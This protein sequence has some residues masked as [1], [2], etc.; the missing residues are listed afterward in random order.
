MR[1]QPLGGIVPCFGVACELHGEC[2]R[3][4]LVEGSTPGQVRLGYCGKGG[5]RA[6]FIPILFETNEQRKPP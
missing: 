5:A 1:A 2:K 6:L 4:A 3:Y